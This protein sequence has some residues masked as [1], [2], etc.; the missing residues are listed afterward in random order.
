MNTKRLA[1][2][3]T[4]GCVLAAAPASAQPEWLMSGAFG[5]HVPL[6][7]YSE[8]ADRGWNGGVQLDYRVRRTFA[9][10]VDLFYSAAS[11][12]ILIGDVDYSILQVG[13]HITG[14][15]RRGDNPLEPYG[16]LAL[17]Y[18]NRNAEGAAF[19]ETEGDVGLS[20]VGGLLFMPRT[21]KIGFGADV[22]IHNVFH[23]EA[24]QYMGVN[25]KLVVS[26]SDR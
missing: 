18:Y 1:L 24:A 6:G 23:D 12:E 22:S 5:A 11:G 2:L 21:S 20:F 7:D 19:E 9:Y 4:F 25:A 13:A 17:S 16:Q 10:G 15:L 26:F 3:V 14:Y 8:L